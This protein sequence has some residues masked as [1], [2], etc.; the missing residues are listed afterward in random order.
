[1]PRITTTSPA[2]SDERIASNDEEEGEEGK[3]RDGSKHGV[4][5]SNARM[6]Q[7]VV[8]ARRIGRTGREV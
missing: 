2:V 8:F 1:V 7:R 6:I 4:D 3:H 5:L